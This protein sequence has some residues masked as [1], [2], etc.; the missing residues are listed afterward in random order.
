[1]REKVE[2]E[3]DRLVKEGILEPVQFSEWGTPIVPVLKKDNTVRICGD[4]RLTVNQACKLDKYPVPRIEDL[5]TKLAGGKVFTK[6]D[7]SQAYL[8]LPLD[9]ESKDYTTITTQKGL[10]RYTRLPFGIASSPAIFQRMMDNLLQDLPKVI[11][12]LDDIL[13]TGD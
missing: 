12:Y 10:F 8:Q 6:L 13:I 9:E 11:V 3:I 7:M 2:V 1:M 5:C 4:Y